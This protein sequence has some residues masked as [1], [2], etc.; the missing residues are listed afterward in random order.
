MVQNI[1]MDAIKLDYGAGMWMAEP[2]DEKEYILSYRLYLDPGGSIPGFAV[3]LLN[4]MNIVN[5]F[6]DVVKEAAHRNITA[7]P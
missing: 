1:S 7:V 2:I 6:K 5:V 3:E 4:K